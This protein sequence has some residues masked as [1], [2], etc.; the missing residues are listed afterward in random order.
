VTLW[1]RIFEERKRVILPLVLAAAANVAVLLLAVIPL[2][3]TVSS[4]EQAAVEATTALAQAERTEQQAI[5][6]RSS[7]ARADEELLKFYTQVLPRDFP[8]AQRTTN[9]WLSQAARDSGLVFK[10]SQFD[11]ETIQDSRLVRAS[12]KI[13][14]EGRYANIRRFLYAVEIAEE[15]IVVESVELAGDSGMAR[16]TLSVT[17][18]VSTYFLPAEGR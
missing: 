9:L 10:G 3:A 15:F 18:G 13:T 17:M 1:Q 6:A 8:T 4:A 7:K 12:S 11:W 5:E 14:L 16:D 2:T